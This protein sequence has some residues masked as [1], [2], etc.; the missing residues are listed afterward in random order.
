MKMLAMVG[1]LR[2]ESYNLQLALTVKERFQDQF[3]M[4]FAD[5]QSL[6]HYNQDWEMDPPEPVIALRKQIVDADGIIIF[7]PEFNWSIPGVLKNALDWVSRVEKV[8][9]GKPVLTA[10]VSMGPMGTIRGQLQMRQ[11]L[12]SPG[13]QVN[14]MP[15]AGNEILV[16][17]AAQ[18]FDPAKM[19]LT[20]E[21]TLQFV[22]GVIAKFIEFVKQSSK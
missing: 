21:A 2:K 7:T 16:T 11:M 13:L 9:I 6:P 18:K 17:H 8:M 4:E 12:Q 19:R 1:S 20:D 22:D 15:P 10:G 14:L 3:S 5:I